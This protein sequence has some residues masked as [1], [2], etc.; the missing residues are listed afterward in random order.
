MPRSEH[1]KIRTE[2]LAVCVSLGLAL[3]KGATAFWTGALTLFASAL[4]SLLDF[5]VSSLNLFALVVSQKGPDED[6]MFGHEK[7]EALGGLFQSVMIVASAAYLIYSSFQRLH[8]P[9]ELKH[10]NEG[11][12][13]IL[14]SMAASFYLTYR[15][16]RV[17]R[18]TGSMVLKADAIHY[19]VDL[20]AYL[21]LLVTFALIQL[22]GWLG[23]DPVVT[24]P[25]SLYIAY[26]GFGVGK[27]AV[28]ELMDRET[29]PEALVTVKQVI[30]RHCPQV[31]G[32]HNF[33]SRRAGGKR[34]IQF[35]VEMKRDLSFH[36]VHEI[37]EV[38]V[39]EI[40]ELL[41]NVHVIIHPDPEGHGEDESDLM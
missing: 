34:Y 12:G 22:S 21:V 10:L 40:R 11:M 3:L 31:T 18:E 4:D 14:I 19:S 1:D 13:V 20:Y 7:A 16:R 41:G 5:L 32:M 25:L 27:E 39:R 38:L 26:Q 8:H 15:L 37:T 36:K 23:W 29:S 35:H 17:S 9:F 28:D 24:L 2:L 33:K 30:S 6:H